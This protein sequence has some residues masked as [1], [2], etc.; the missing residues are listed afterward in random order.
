MLYCGVHAALAY[1]SS[2]HNHLLC[3]FAHT[4]NRQWNAIHDGLVT[5]TENNLPGHSLPE[6]WPSHAGL[7]GK[8]ASKHRAWAGRVFSS[9]SIN[10]YTG[11][12]SKMLLWVTNHVE[13]LWVQSL[14]GHFLHSMCV[15]LVTQCAQINRQ[16]LQCEAFRGTTVTR[17]H[18]AK[19]QPALANVECDKIPCWFLLLGKFQCFHANGEGLEHKSE[20]RSQISSP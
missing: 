17:S 10:T 9:G 11:R 15:F 19:W 13:A 3:V 8:V 12:C 16:R 1:S 7:Y 5:D 2:N 18:L 6:G 20:I 14:L 4:Q